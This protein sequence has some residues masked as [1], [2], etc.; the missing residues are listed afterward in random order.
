[1][2]LRGKG[3]CYTNL[4]PGNYQK[5]FLIYTIILHSGGITIG[6]AI[7]T[8]AH[9]SSLLHP[10]SLSDQVIR[11][12]VISGD[13]S[14]L[15]IDSREEVDAFRVHLGLLGI[16]VDITFPTVPLFKMTIQNR[17]MSDSILFNNSLPSLATQYDM[18]QAWWFPA[19]GQVVL[20]TGNYTSADTV[21]TATS[22]FIPNE[23]PAMIA[24]SNSAFNALQATRSTT[25]LNAF[26]TFTELSLFTQ[27]VGKPPVYSEDGILI[28]NPATGYAW[29][30]QSNRC[31]NGTLERC[32]WL[33]GAGTSIFPEESSI[34]FDISQFTGVMTM[35]RKV[36]R[37]YPASFAL[38]GIYIRFSPAS[39]AL[40][41]ISSGRT[42]FTVEWTTP[43]RRNPFTESRDGIA[44]YQMILQEMVS[45]KIIY[46]MVALNFNW[47]YLGCKLWRS[48]AL[49]K[50][51]T[52]LH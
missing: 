46:I 21:G 33:N 19:A 7:G 29:R 48:T 37:E 42:T 17:P 43:M 23:P 51:W 45:K 12:T 5:I 40:M 8:G 22:N 26:A 16:I 18:F 15:V 9:G 35:I 14:L 49:G 11:L 34:A 32:S 31:G 47:M 4:G 27:V 44:A 38:V 2:R 10:T 20:G 36:I 1:M 50:K 28:K 41:A 6:G 24:L 30:L 13:G 25:A 3:G 39:P 52:P